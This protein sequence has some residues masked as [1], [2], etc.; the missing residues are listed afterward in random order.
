MRHFSSILPL[1]PNLLTLGQSN[2]QSLHASLPKLNDWYLQ[3]AGNPPGLSESEDFHL[4]A[5]A[6]ALYTSQNAPHP[7]W[8]VTIEQILNS[9]P[10]LLQHILDTDALAVTMDTSVVDLY[11]ILAEQALR[12]NQSQQAFNTLAKLADKTGLAA[13]RFLVAWI[14]FNVNDLEHCINEC[15]KVNEPFAPIHTLLGQALLESGKVQSAIEALTV[16]AE[17][18]PRDPL[19]LVQLVKAYIIIGRQQDCFAAINRC[20]KIV[21]N[22]LEIECLAS[23]AILAGHYRPQDFCLH[24]LGNIAAKIEENPHDFQAFAIGMELA[25]ELNL[26]NWAQRY[27]ETWDS[28]QLANPQQIAKELTK[29]LK[30]HQERNWHDVSRIVLDKTIAIGKHSDLK[31]VMQ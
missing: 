14:A 30:R 1:E 31:F 27:A 10:S 18:A 24:T 9:K 11:G 6:R 21:G 20:R 22:N 12:N 5:L 3:R 16:A 8:S 28:S 2:F 15:E 23:I 19:P 17:I 13:F 7:S 25:A 4:F 29:I 26:K